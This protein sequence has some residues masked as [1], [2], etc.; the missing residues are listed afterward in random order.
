MRLVCVSNGPLPYHTPILNRV[1]KLAELHVVYM[2]TGHPLN[3]FLDLWG[4]RPEFDYSLYRSAALTVPRLDFRTQ[5]SAGISRVLAHHD[6]DAVFFS[7][8]GPLVWEP[9]IWARLTGRGTV[10]WS[11]STEWSGLARGRISTAARRG[12]TGVV[13]AF[14]TNG[15]QA[16][17][18]L[19]QL[20]VPADR[21]VTS[22]LP[23]PLSVEPGRTGDVASPAYLFVGRL[24]PRKRPQQALEAFSTVRSRYPEATLAFVGDGPLETELRAAARELGEAVVFRGRLEGEQLAAALAAADVLVLPAAREV[25]GLVVNE[26]LASGLYVV[27]SDEVGSA[28]DLLTPGSGEMVPVGDPGALAAALLRAA[29]ADLGPEARAARSRSVAEVTPQSFADDLVAAARIASQVR[30]RRRTGR[31]GA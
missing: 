14:V 23:S 21:I 11:E 7:S 3:S 12:I 16:A 29:E 26:A 25:W 4:G 5:V 15:T 20:G 22:R 13:D 6:P 30:R 18:Y 2:S 8:W 27:A 9:A 28:Y 31:R 17:A 1:A 24:I 19:R 10:M